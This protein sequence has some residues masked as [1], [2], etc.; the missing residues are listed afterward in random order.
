MNTDTDTG[1]DTDTDI[2]AIRPPVVLGTV[3]QDR[4]HPARSW[5]RA[6]LACS[7]SFPCAVSTTSPSRPSAGP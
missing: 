3:D 2:T 7:G 5:V 1:T 4:P 6:P